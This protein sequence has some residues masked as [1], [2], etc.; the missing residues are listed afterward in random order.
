MRAVLFDLDGTL[1]D[2]DIEEFL[3][4]YFEALGPVVAEVTGTDAETG[5]EAVMAATR[6]MFASHPGQTNAEKFAQAFGETTGSD[7]TDADWAR[8]D[9]FYQEVFPTLRGSLGPNRGAREAVDA[10]VRAGCMV[11][12]ATN[13]I[14]PEA[15]IRQRIEWAGLGDVAFAAVTS[16]ENSSATKPH[17]GYYREVAANLGVDPR[18]C[19]MVG[20]D[21]YLDMSA[22]D[23]GMRTFYVGEMPGPSVDFAG[24]LEDL[25]VLIPRLCENGA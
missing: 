14:F 25:A 5:L 17:P 15:A 11:A 3:G 6:A 21:P 13:P 2:I 7:L 16:Y 24:S 4:R 9:R 22:A 10:A 12:I 20:D 8:F 18:D 19:L 23:V 1:L